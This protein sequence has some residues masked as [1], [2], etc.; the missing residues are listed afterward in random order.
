MKITDDV[1]EEGANRPPTKTHISQIVSGGQTGVD[2]AALDA[3]VE[4][5]ISIGGWCP[6]G[7]R[8]EDGRIPDGYPLKETAAR[9][10]AIRT[11]W[12]VRD[13]DGTL[14][15]VQDEISSGTRLTVSSARKQ[16]QPYLVVHLR[17]DADALFEDQP[18]LDNQIKQVLNW[19]VENEIKVLNVA[20]PRGSSN[21]SV[22]SEAREFLSLLFQKVDRE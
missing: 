7:R 6:R 18:C 8:S 14:I 15:I 10:Y 1:I 21:A 22:Y 5:N 9:S 19:L 3:A 2:R 12:N 11:E 16:N 4:A 13:S 17:P 20:G